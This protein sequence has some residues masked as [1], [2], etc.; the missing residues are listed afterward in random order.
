MLKLYNVGQLMICT[1]INTFRAT[2]STTM[3]FILSRTSGLFFEVDFLHSGF[4]ITYMSGIIHFR[5]NALYLTK[6]AHYHVYIC[7]NVFKNTLEYMNIIP[8]RLHGKT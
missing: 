6:H 7:A 1:F 5:N 2:R 4:E 3:D 8:R